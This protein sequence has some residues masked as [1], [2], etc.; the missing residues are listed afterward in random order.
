MEPKQHK[1]ARALIR[2]MCCYYDQGDCLALEDADRHACAQSL[3]LTL[4]CH[5]FRW[6]L[7]PME[8]VL[9]A[10]I[11]RDKD[12]K[13]CAVCGK[14]FVAKSNRAKYCTECAVRVRRLQKTESERKRRAKVDV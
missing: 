2:K 1:Q 8:A 12:T 11:F 9:E 3:S 13:K 5:W 4:C 7:L 14:V 6:V 10:E